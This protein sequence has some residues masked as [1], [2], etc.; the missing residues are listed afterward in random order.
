MH[1]F[2]IRKHTTLLWFVSGLVRVRNCGAFC[3]TR[4]NSANVPYFHGKRRHNAW[5]LYK[6]AQ[7]DAL[8]DGVLG[9]FTRRRSA[10]LYKTACLGALQDGV[11]GRFTR[12]RSATHTVGEKWH[13]LHHVFKCRCDVFVA[14]FV[15]CA[16]LTMGYINNDGTSDVEDL[17]TSHTAVAGMYVC[18]C[19]YVHVCVYVHG[20]DVFKLCFLLLQFYG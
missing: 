1:H 10:T 2:L 15:T 19:M 7:C 9:R 20:C 3:Q 18:T 8:Q 12:R 5:A 6:T 17:H 14:F 13:T 4:R 11:L 16:V